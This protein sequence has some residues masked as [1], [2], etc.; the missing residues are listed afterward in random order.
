M[1]KSRFKRAKTIPSTLQFHAFILD[2]DGRLHLKKFS[3]S[4]DIDFSPH[5]K[6]RIQIRG[7]L[8][9]QA[10]QEKNCQSK[11]KINKNHH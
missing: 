9:K 7:H 11:R 5:K 8:S 4:T 10:E 3:A 2:N 6:E 1:M